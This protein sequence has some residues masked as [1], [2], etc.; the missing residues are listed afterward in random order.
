MNTP[1]WIACVAADSAGHL[2]P[3][4]TLAQQEQARNPHC[5]ILFITADRSTERSFTAQFPADIKLLY[6]PHF[7]LKKS[8]KGICSSLFTSARVFA[9]SLYTFHTHKPVLLITTGGAF[10][11]PV[12]IAAW[13]LRIPITAFELNASVGKALKYSAPLATTIYTCFPSAQQELKAYKAQLAPYP[14][15][16]FSASVADKATVLP[17]LGL[18]PTKVTLL[19]VGGSQG[20]T[21]LNRCMEYL[22]INY[23]TFFKSMQLIH[24]TGV[25]QAAS[26]KQHYQQVGIQ[27]FVC[28]F[29]PRLP[30]FLQVADVVVCRAGAGTLF[31]LRALKKQCITIPLITKATSHQLDNARYFATTF[32][33]HFTLLYQTAVEQHPLAL[34]NAI[35]TRLANY[36]ASYQD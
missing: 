35:K 16:S 26:F 36:Q 9:R 10:S 28:D 34:L 13:L 3:C 12:C 19:I 33:T 31:E 6:L 14:L 2:F 18:D 5:S 29:D 30:A 7:A 32:P 23:P 24:Q 8:I 20:S 21:F 1:A 17:S 25:A 11:V 15:R 27:A 4:L 22:I